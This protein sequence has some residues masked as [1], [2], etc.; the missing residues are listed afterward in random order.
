M[1]ANNAIIDWFI[2]CKSVAQELSL[3]SNRGFYVQQSPA[4][5]SSNFYK[6]HEKFSRHRYH[7]DDVFT[8][9]FAI[10]FLFFPAVL[11]FD[12]FFFLHF[13]KTQLISVIFNGLLILVLKFCLIKLFAR[14]FFLLD[15]SQHFV[16]ISCVSNIFVVVGTEKNNS[17]PL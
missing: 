7:A 3:F 5:F 9:S 10:S 16:Q 13:T 12:V 1:V 8:A 14:F 15:K 2:I 17:A 6:N 4:Q 11:L